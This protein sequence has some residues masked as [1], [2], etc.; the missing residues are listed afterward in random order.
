MFSAYGYNLGGPRGWNLFRFGAGDELRTDWYDETDPTHDFPAQ[1]RQSLRAWP[2]TPANGGDLELP[3]LF[4]E[5]I[6]VSPPGWTLETG[7]R[8]SSSYSLPPSSEL[9]SLDRVAVA[10]FVVIHADSLFDPDAE[11][12]AHHQGEDYDVDPAIGG[13]GHWDGSLFDALSRLGLQ[14]VGMPASLWFRTGWT[15]DE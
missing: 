7:A 5:A 10:Q 13:T 4:L 8:P 1:A 9:R 12:L 6:E 2:G 14:P 15:E 11:D 3:V